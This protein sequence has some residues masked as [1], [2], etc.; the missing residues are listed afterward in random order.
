MSR[1]PSEHP[2]THKF[3]MLIDDET[4]AQ[5]DEVSEQLCA[6]R[7]EVAR[8]GIKKIYKEMK[9]GKRNRFL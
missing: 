7:S 4:K 9:E 3:L 6:S 2:K 8:R 1:L 5:L